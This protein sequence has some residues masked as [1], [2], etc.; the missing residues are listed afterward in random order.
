MKAIRT[1]LVSQL[2]SPT[3]MN[4]AKK[5]E[6]KKASKIIAPDEF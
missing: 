5:C 2:E 1:N 4:I 3:E 6:V